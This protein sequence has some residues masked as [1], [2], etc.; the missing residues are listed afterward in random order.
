[1]ET[2]V[3]MAILWMPLLMVMSRNVTWPI[4]ACAYNDKQL[5]CI[6]LGT[7]FFWF[8]HVSVFFILSFLLSSI[9]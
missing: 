3:T 8:R 1:M 4:T 7:Y 9:A 5:A 6:G 2:A